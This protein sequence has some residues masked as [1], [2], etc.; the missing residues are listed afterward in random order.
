VENSASIMTLY[1]HGEKLMSKTKYMGP[2][3]EI[4]LIISIL[5][6]LLIDS[7]AAIEDLKGYSAKYTGI[8]LRGHSQQ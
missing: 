7:F 4:F 5:G 2:F 3:E 8:L 6:V 1:A